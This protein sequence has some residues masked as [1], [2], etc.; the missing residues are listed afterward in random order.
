[1]RGPGIGIMAIIM[2]GIATG[3]TGITGIIPIGITG[4]IIMGAVS[5][6]HT[7]IVGPIIVLITGRMPTATGHPIILPIQ[8][9]VPITATGLIMAIA[10]TTATVPIMGTG[11]IIGRGPASR[12]DFRPPLACTHTTGRQSDAGGLKP[13]DALIPG[14]PAG[15]T[16]ADESISGMAGH[17]MWS[18][19]RQA[20]ALENVRIG[21]VSRP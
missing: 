18:A 6:G 10:H 20:A 13:G 1:M 5:I 2:T 17:A 12:L 4:L 3:I 7:T 8:G 9:T 15:A 11:P 19:P 14:N 21:G 16:A